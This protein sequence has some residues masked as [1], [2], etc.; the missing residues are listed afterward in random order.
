MKALS[1]L[2]LCA[3][4]LLSFT[5]C[6]TKTAVN[7]TISSA[8]AGAVVSCTGDGVSASGTIGG[9]TGT[10]L[11]LAAPVLAPNGVTVTLD[12]ARSAA[13]AAPINVKCVYDALTRSAVCTNPKT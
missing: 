11:G 8:A 10:A 13:D 7:C 9:Q 1:L 4:S 3:L 6:N 12:S 2:A 5:G